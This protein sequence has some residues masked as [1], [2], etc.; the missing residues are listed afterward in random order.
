MSTKIVKDTLTNEQID[1]LQYFIDACIDVKLAQETKSAD[2]YYTNNLSE[3]RLRQ[4][5]REEL[6]E[7]FQVEVSQ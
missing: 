6:R 5:A 7:A 2:G 1:A 4:Q 3:K